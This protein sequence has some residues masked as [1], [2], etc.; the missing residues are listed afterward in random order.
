M[1]SDLFKAPKPAEKTTPPS[2]NAGHNETN[3]ISASA[4]KGEAEYTHEDASTKAE[5]LLH[6]LNIMEVEINKTLSEGLVVDIYNN[7][8][9]IKKAVEAAK[10]VLYECMP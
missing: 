10:D 3:A 8:V 9:T 4:H 1:L 5:Y 2:G 6:M 7:S